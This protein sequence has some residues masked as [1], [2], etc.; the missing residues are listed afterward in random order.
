MISLFAS[1]VKTCRPK[2][3]FPLFFG[4][5]LYYQLITHCETLININGHYCAMPQNLCWPPFLI[6][7][8]F[9]FFKVCFKNVN[10]ISCLQLWAKFYWKIYES[11]FSTFGQVTFSQNENSFL[12]TILKRN[13][14]WSF[15]WLIYSCFGYTHMVQLSCRNS[16]GKVG[17]LKNEWVQVVPTILCTNR[18]E[19]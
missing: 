16:Y 11:G 17:I 6:R 1:P 5:C 9:F 18:S 10:V 13:I 4:N 15:F 2:D 19:K 8:F 14:F 12:A 3:F 7:I